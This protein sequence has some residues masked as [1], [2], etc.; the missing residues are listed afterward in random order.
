MAIYTTFEEVELNLPK[1]IVLRKE[2][3]DAIRLAK[4]H[5]GKNKRDVGYSLNPN[6]QQF[7]WNAKMRFGKTLCALEL[8]KQMN[9]RRI[10]IVTHRPAVNEEWIKAFKE[11]FSAVIENYNY[12]T[13]SDTQSEGDFY[14]SLIPQ[15]FSLTFFIS[16]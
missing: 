5:F 4:Q 8:A 10:L 14:A 13:K 12:G 7:L 11:R 1:K 6:F 3:K 2:Q 9:V 15:H 16:T